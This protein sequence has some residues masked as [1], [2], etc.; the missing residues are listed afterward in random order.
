MRGA[1]AEGH[2]HGRANY[3]MFVW[4]IGTPPETALRVTTHSTANDQW[5]DLWIGQ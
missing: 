5:P 4:R 1:S 3:E 2:E